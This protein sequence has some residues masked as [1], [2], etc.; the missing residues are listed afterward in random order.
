MFVCWSHCNRPDYI[1]TIMLY[2]EI[3]SWPSSTFVP[4]LP[5]L[6]TQTMGRLRAKIKVVGI[7]GF[8]PGF[9]ISKLQCHSYVLSLFRN[10]KRFGLLIPDD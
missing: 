6:L 9:Q 5:V 8:A 10:L 7:Q 3:M 1:F 2:E 4:D